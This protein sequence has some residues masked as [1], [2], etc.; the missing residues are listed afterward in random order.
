MRLRQKLMRRA[1]RLL[2]RQIEVTGVLPVA[3]PAQWQNS[4][5]AALPLPLPSMPGVLP[6]RMH[7][8]TATALMATGLDFLREARN[9][10]AALPGVERP[11]VY[12]PWR[13]LADTDVAL[14]PELLRQRLA[15]AGERA[16]G[17]FTVS[18]DGRHRLWLL[19]AS[20]EIWLGWC[21]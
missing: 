9:A 8:H 12:Q 13:S 7:A 14:L 3:S 17:A 5:L 18:G 20:A 21:D 11:G 10:R 1:Q 6:L 15:D 16:M 2:P 19:P 4:A